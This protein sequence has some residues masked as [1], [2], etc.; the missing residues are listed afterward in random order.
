MTDYVQGGM[1]GGLTF[2]PIDFNPTFGPQG[3]TVAP[4]ESSL[5]YLG[6]NPNLNTN[7]PGS[8]LPTNQQFQLQGSTISQGIQG[9]TISAPA[10]T[11]TPN[12]TQTTPSSNPANASAGTAGGGPAGG[13]LADYFARAI[14]IVL[15]FIFVAVG[16][17]M[18]RPGTVPLPGRV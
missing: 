17:N 8:T 1:F 13:S 3:P 10:S 9:A 7:I 11:S 18:L 2:A 14:I 16:L 12:T 4:N 15:G 5:G 6:T